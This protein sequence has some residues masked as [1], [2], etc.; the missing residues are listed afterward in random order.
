MGPPERGWDGRLVVGRFRRSW[1][2]V[3]VV[4]RLLGRRTCSRCRWWVV[5]L[6]CGGLRRGGGGVGVILLTWLVFGEECGVRMLRRKKKKE[7]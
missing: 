5:S 6:E 7:N 2:R 3:V 4:R 1:G